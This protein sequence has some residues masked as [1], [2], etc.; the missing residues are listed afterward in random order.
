MSQNIP[1]DLPTIS[2]LIKPFDNMERGLVIDS[3]LSRNMNANSTI[4]SKNNKFT[5]TDNPSRSLKMNNSSNDQK[6][7]SENSLQYSSKDTAKRVPV[8]RVKGIK[9]NLWRRLINQ[10]N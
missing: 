6:S 3:A 10:K 2:K 5:N 7:T 9:S 4:V 1:C 8:D